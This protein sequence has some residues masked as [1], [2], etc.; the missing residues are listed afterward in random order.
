MK[1]RTYEASGISRVAMISLGLVVLTSTASYMTGYGAPRSVPIIMGLLFFMLNV[2][3]RFA[4]QAIFLFLSGHKSKRKRVAIYGAGSAGIQLASALN[5]TDEYNPVCFIDAHPNLNGVI[6]SGLQVHAPDALEAL[7]ASKNLD[8]IILAI[9]SLPNDR[10]QEILKRLSRFKCQIKT[11]PS[12][13]ELVKG[14]ELVSSLMT[15]TPESL[16]GRDAINLDLPEVRNTYKDK[17]VMVTGAGGSIG[18]ELCRQ[19]LKCDVKKLVLYE[20]S[21]FALYTIHQEFY[22]HE[23]VVAVPILGSVLDENHLKRALKAEDVQIILH[24]AAYK[25]VPLVEDNEIVGVENNVLGTFTVAKAAKDLMLERFILIST[26]KAVRP[27][28]VMGA[29]KRV[30]ELLVQNLAEN[31]DKT[32]FSMVRFGNVLGSSGSVIPLFKKQIDEGGPVRLTH[33][34]VTRFFMT[35][36]EAASLV[37]LAGSYAEGGDVFVLDMGEPVRIYDLARSMIELS[38]KTVKDTDNPDGDIEIHV[39]G[40]RPGEK[41]YEELLIDDAQISTPHPKILRASEVSLSMK[42]CETMLGEL[43]NGVENPRAFLK[44]WVAEYSAA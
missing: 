9:P 11:L 10:R 16:L 27:T 41:L 4:I 18:S 32:L 22:D 38:G 28:N 30:A 3:S 1:T 29:T 5:L 17:V 43:E 31:C 19:L 24:A 33:N 40:L 39:T 26:D 36:P 25:H 37:L 7:V 15:V 34:D 2:M 21:E 35:I 42:D 20:H 8:E 23:T 6:V 13:V 44:K 14:K 12:L